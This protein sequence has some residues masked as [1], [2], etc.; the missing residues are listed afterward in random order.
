[1]IMQKGSNMIPMKKIVI[2]CLD[3][4]LAWLNV[5]QTDDVPGIQV[6]NKSWHGGY[7]SGNDNFVILTGNNIMQNLANVIKDAPIF[8]TFG[9]RF[10]IIGPNPQ[11]FRCCP[12][13]KPAEQCKILSFAIENNSG[14]H[15]DIQNRLDQPGWFF[16]YDFKVVALPGLTTEESAKKYYLVC[17]ECAKCKTCVTTKQNGGR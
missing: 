12:C 6:K 11:T 8:T 2:E 13:E 10:Q 9:K 14:A 3:D 15:I 7:C 1:M 4:T 16:N 17:Q 5:P